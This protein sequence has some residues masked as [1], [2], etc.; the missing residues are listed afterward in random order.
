M[1]LL[2]LHGNQKG[3]VEDAYL[4]GFAVF[5]LLII[6]KDWALNKYSARK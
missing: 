6:F 5:I 3:H 2:M 4:I 1:L